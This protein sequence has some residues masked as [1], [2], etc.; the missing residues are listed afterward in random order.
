[1]AEK[2]AEELRKEKEKLE[3]K[4]TEAKE[5]EEQARLATVQVTHYMYVD[6]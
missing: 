2:V 5:I 4:L 3:R 6:M 1:M